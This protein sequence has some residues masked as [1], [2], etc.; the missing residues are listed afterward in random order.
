MP[1]LNSVTLLGNLTRDPELRYT[2]SGNPVC[3]LALAVNRRYRKG[4]EVAEDVCYVDVD[5][6][7]NLAEYITSTQAKGSLVLVQGR[8]ALDTWEDGQGN[9][10]SKHKIHAVSVE[11]FARSEEA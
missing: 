7:G 10:R 11:T 3:N 6:W 8:L 2:P 1:S 5:V 4:N 9:K